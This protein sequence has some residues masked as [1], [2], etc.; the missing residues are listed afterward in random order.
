MNA[1]IETKEVVEKKTL[2]NLKIKR[3]M[4]GLTLYVKSP[5][6]EEFFN[7]MSAGKA[8]AGSSGLVWGQAEKYYD[9]KKC[10]IPRAEYEKSINVTGYGRSDI[11]STE[12]GIHDF[13][14]IKTVGI[15]DGVT[16][17][18]DGMFLQDEIEKF[19]KDFAKFTKSFFISYAKETSI[20][21]SITAII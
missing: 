2:C 19:Q 14:F 10:S 13:S 21:V 6:F 3:D 16:F 20:E 1:K 8:L 9:V 15:K 7:R 18:I 4:G 17:R 11:M 5:L 12:N